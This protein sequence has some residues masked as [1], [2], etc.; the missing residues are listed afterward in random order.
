MENILNEAKAIDELKEMLQSSPWGYAYHKILLDE[1]GCPEDYEFLHVN[2]AFEELTGLKRENLLGH[3]VTE[4]IPGIEKSEFDWIGFYGKIALEG[5]NEIFEQF[6]EPLER[7]YKVQVFS[8]GKGYFSTLF[9]DISSERKKTEELENF[10]AVNPDLLC[11]ADIHGNFVKNNRAWEG[12][13]GYTAEEL[14]G[15]QFLDFVHPDDLEDTLKVMGKLEKQEDVLNF[16]NRYRTR[17]GTYRFI[18]WRSRPVG[19]LIFAAARD[20]TEERRIFQ[21]LQ[22]QREQFQLALRGTDDG[23]WDWDIRRGKLFFSEHWKKM[24]GYDNRELPDNFETF[25]SLLW[26]EDRE[27]VLEY[28]ESYLRE[29]VPK[30][31]IEFRMKHKD[32]SLRWILSKGEALRDEKG[33]P[34]RMVGS[35]SDITERKKIEL[36]L[37]RERER[38]SSILEGTRAGTW[39]WNVQTG[40]ITLNERWA[41]MLGYTL[42]ELQ[43]LSIATWTYFSHPEDFERGKELLEKHFRGE[44]EYY[45]NEIRMKHREGRWIWVQNR[46]KVARWTGDGKPLLMSGTHQDITERKENE[47]RLKSSEENFR[48]FFET[49]DDLIIIGNRK[50][51]IFYVNPAV[52]E[53]LGYAKED[54]QELNVFDLC[55]ETERNE[56]KRK[57]IVEYMLERKRNVASVSLENEKRSFRARGKP[58]VVWSM[59]RQRSS[60]QHFQGHFQGAGGSAKV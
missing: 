53:K 41:E 22:D 11:I 30:Y 44:L 57:E 10:F 58:N 12:I 4:V 55:L 9:V 5:G 42:K 40:E 50:G 23:I 15:R 13:L 28:M 52:T 54:L 1:K 48:A 18:E 32:G 35:H 51:D 47:E 24:L 29:E 6:S 2:R 33:L 38:L 27:R 7:W 21:K 37:A 34:Y 36:Q 31:S 3:R 26:E 14:Q 59:E 16:V 17:N 19:K 56:A 45:E 8:S 20:V 43:P 46:G 39:E 25:P 49:M 60:L